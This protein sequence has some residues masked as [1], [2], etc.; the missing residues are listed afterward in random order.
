MDGRYGS[1]IDSSGSG[2]GFDRCVR[3]IYVDGNVRSR[4]VFG[5]KREKAT[6]KSRRYGYSIRACS[7]WKWKEMVRLDLVGRNAVFSMDASV[8]YMNL[9][10]ELYFCKKRKHIIPQQSSF[11]LLLPPPPSFPIPP[12]TTSQKPHPLHT[13][14]STPTLPHPQTSAIALLNAL[15]TFPRPTTPASP[16]STISS[17]SFWVLQLPYAVMK[18]W[19]V[20]QRFWIAMAL[21]PVRPRVV[22]VGIARCFQFFVFFFGLF[23]WDIQ[24]GSL[25]SFFLLVGKTRKEKGERVRAKFSWGRGGGRKHTEHL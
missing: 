10:H 12:H 16:L 3:R 1:S 14:P 5:G 7:F 6:V 17:F 4:A 21:S 11:Y 9:C 13:P 8:P 15:P 22:T 18:A 19:G 25:I 24:P 23:F 2:S 20:V